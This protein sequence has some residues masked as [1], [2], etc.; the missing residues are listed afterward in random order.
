MSSSAKSIP[1]LFSENEMKNEESKIQA[2]VNRK[3][4]R[5]FNKESV[6]GTEL[7]ASFDLYN[8]SLPYANTLRRIL[9]SRVP[10]IA[11]DDTWDNDAKSRSIVIDKN[12]SGIHNEFLSHRLALVPIV[13]S[14]PN[15]AIHTRFDK[16]T[17]KR[18]FDFTYP[19]DVPV[20]KIHRKNNT[21][22]RND[23][24]EKGMLTVTSA[25]FTVEFPE[26][27][28]EKSNERRVLKASDYFTID[29]Y[30][31]DVD[32]YIPINKLKRNLVNENEGE[33]M[34]VLCRPTIGVGYQNARYD[35]TGNVAFQYKKEDEKTVEQI[36][37]LKL[38][39]LNNER[40]NKKLKD[41]TDDEVT[42]LRR[43]FQLLDSER[44]YKKNP[45]GTPSVFQYR[46]E[47]IGF[48]PPIQIMQTALHM[49]RL[50]LSDLKHCIELS[51]RNQTLDIVLNSK[52]TMFS[53][54]H[55]ENSWVIR[56]ADEDHTLGN[57][58][59]QELRTIY[60]EKKD[61]L[62]YTAYKMNHPLIH[63]VDIVIVPKLTRNI[64]IQYIS[65]HYV[66]NKTFMDLQWSKTFIEQLGDEELYKLAS[67]CYF[68]SSVNRLIEH[69]NELISEV[70][71]IELVDPVFTNLDGDTYFDKYSDL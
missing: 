12:T 54:P 35:P 45:D 70:G 49:L 4:I 13:M 71:S 7:R 18:V 62:Q 43:S 30:V 39:Y 36:F 38:E 3:Y 40:R 21:E 17:A 61:L 47:S 25:D 51:Y 50:Q 24:D 60:Q 34:K 11:F 69:T 53:S 29:P 31:N 68:I 63:N 55:Q 33:E 57:L 41:F 28:G 22:T 26:E 66:N 8:C 23:L 37:Q 64:H 15:L 9:S 1:S 59:S 65:S 16:K 44:V 5:N 52:L 32:G 6:N 2:A 20:F 58:I 19:E 46:I 48:M 67:I 14:N 56:I 27:E 10:T 42:Q